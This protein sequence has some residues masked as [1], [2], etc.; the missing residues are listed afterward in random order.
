MEKVIIVGAGP[1]G[2]FAGMELAP[3][4]DVTIIDMGKDARSRH[5]DVIRKG[6]CSDCDVCDVICG[7]GGAGGMSDGKLNLHPRVGGDLLEFVDEETAWK[8]IRKVEVEFA[9][10]FEEGFSEGDSGKLSKISAATGIE[11]LPI[12]QKHIGSDR[13]PEAIARIREKLEGMGVK[14][15]LRKK[16]QDVIVENGR[17]GGVILSDGSKIRSDY[18]LLAVGRAGTRWMADIANKLGIGL[19]YMPIDV[20]VRV[21][22]PAV[23]YEDVVRINWDPKFRMRTPT[24]DDSVR[25][26][27]T[28]PYG[29]V[30][31]DDY[32]GVI[33]VNGHSMSG[34]RSENTNFA[35]LVRIELTEPVENTTAYGMSI[36][37][38]A[39]T[40]GGGKPLIQRLGDLEMGRRST[41]KRI[42]R[43]YVKPTLKY[44]TPGD[45]GMA[46][47]HRIVTDIIEGLE[48]LDRVVEGVASDSTL[49]YAPEIKF[50]A[51][52]V[53][54]GKYLE[55]DINGLFVAG[56]GAGLSRGFV[57]A[58]CT[59]M[60][61]ARGILRESGK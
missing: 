48:M 60:I 51:M 54:T 7:V 13:L 44:V 25:T 47:P 34:K 59:G 37:N 2:L 32:G 24:Y 5:C 14:F 15:L 18:V 29:F 57:T 6:I 28:C 52:R 49:L 40:I 16:V 41:W 11:F 27:C 1:A 38:L 33:G 4:F 50:S 53:K 31:K 35:L 45:I 8:L 20:G 42:G 26:F 22:V 39:N 3:H 12:N 46:M 30:I 10:F 19:E 21:E 56:D 61:A 23:V 9:D 55:T 43:S 17:V 58:G 36:A